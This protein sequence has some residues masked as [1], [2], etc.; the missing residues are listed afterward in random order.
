M[1]APYTV[2]LMGGIASGKSAAARRM[3]ALGASRIDL[4]A[5]SHEL[6]GP[7]MPLLDEIASEFGDDLIDSETGEL[8]RGLLADR[9]F[10][11]AESAAR[12]EAIEHPAIIARL[13]D[14]LLEC[15]CA[16]SIPEACVV[17]V[18]LP[19]RMGEAL[20]LADELIAVT[21]PRELRRARAIGRGMTG[22]DFDARDALQPDEGYLL[23]IA[24]TVF[25]NSG[26]AESLI[27]Q[28][29]AW[30]D[31]RFSKDRLL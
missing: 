8:N 24:H 6:L 3:E 20:S 16:A 28:V 11:S 14:I 5:I 12:L 19:D 31:L 22:D 2:F 26:S 10:A 17:E 9:A 7:G 25:D 29:D 4:D 13:G 18:P 23:G 1:P 27:A 15:G 30:W 21:C